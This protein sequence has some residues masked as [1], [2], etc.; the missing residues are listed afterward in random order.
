MDLA[1][2]FFEEFSV[3][4]FEDTLVEY[5]MFDIEQDDAYVESILMEATKDATKGSILER[6]MTAVKNALKWIWD[7]LKA[8]GRWVMSKLNKKNS[9][10]ADQI[11]GD[12]AK[13]K[14]LNKGS[15]ETVVTTIEGDPDSPVKMNEEVESM[16][17]GLEFAFKDNSVDVTIHFKEI[18]FKARKRGAKI[19]K[20]APNVYDILLAIR[21][22]SDPEYRN[23]LNAA[24]KNIDLE[25]G[26]V[27]DRNNSLKDLIAF[28]EYIELMIANAGDDLKGIFKVSIKLTD[29]AEATKL[30]GHAIDVVNKYGPTLIKPAELNSKVGSNYN[31][32][33]KDP[34][35]KIDLN[36]GAGGNFFVDASFIRQMNS[37]STALIITSYGMNQLT[38]GLNKVYDIDARYLGCIKDPEQLSLFAERMVDSGIPSKYIMRNIYLAANDKMK[39]K[40]SEK[41]PIWGQTRVIF[42]PNGGNNILKIAYNRAG[43]NA[44]KNEEYL[45]KLLSD[46]DAKK[47]IANVL[48][49][50]NNR[51]IISM[52]KVDCNTK[53]VR[54]RMDECNNETEKIHN[55]LIVK[56]RV[57]FSVNDLHYMNFGIRPDGSCCVVDYGSVTYV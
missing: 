13:D 57:R 38:Y 34:E 48:G 49:S 27:T 5:P 31:S 32:R 52:E 20:I 40:G 22:I 45:T 21:L 41:K 29:I 8:F 10:T 19:G 37:F 28:N 42:I 4:G 55:A 18:F 9:K 51:F 35:R 7:K 33:W 16:F 56:K 25:K 6:L 15:E 54:R 17:K 1:Y 23:K 43:V 39:G 24:L 44:N 50:T 26:Q 11:I 46:T 53:N 36:I 3:N 12:I 47:S 30:I 2:P 14:D